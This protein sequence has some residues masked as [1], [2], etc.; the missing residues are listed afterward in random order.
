[1]RHMSK[2]TNNFH[3]IYCS[4]RISTSKKNLQKRREDNIRALQYLGIKSG[5]VSYI[6]DTF[7]VEDNYIYKSSLEILKYLSNLI[8]ESN[9]KQVFTLNLEGGHP[10]H[11]FIA[12]LVNKLCIKYKFKSFYFPAYNY[13]RSLLLPFSV[14][15]PLKTQ[16]NDYKIIRFNYFCWM[17]VLI[18]A[19]FYRTERISFL[20]LMPGLI[21]KSIF[22]RKLIYY[23]SINLD[24]VI[25]TKSLTLKRY[26]VPINSLISEINNLNI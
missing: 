5:Q 19:L 17:R 6:N 14:L 10:D 21:Y 8:I 9:F 3:I 23:E 22:S 15:R 2:K 18:I 16:E 20:F 24:K 4:E 11:D 1:M 25:W 26:N 12:L 7:N 13:R